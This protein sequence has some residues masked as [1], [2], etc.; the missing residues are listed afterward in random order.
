MRINKDNTEIC[1]EVKEIKPGKSLRGKW[2]RFGDYPGI[3]RAGA[4]LGNGEPG[5]AGGS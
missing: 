4:A 2:L 5:A 3:F 1:L